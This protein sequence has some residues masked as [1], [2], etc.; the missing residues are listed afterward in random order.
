MTAR[1]ILDKAVRG[2]ELSA[3]EGEA[4]FALEGEA[5]RDLT[6]AADEVRRQRCGE[7]VTYVVNRN[8]KSLTSV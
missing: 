7:R 6:G 2:E 4:L 3:G 8:I 5:L 1:K